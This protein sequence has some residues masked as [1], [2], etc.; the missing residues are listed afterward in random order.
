MYVVFVRTPQ[1]KPDALPNTVCASALAADNDVPADSMSTQPSA[2][3][4]NARLQ[5]VF[6]EQQSSVS[7]IQ[8]LVQQFQSVFPV[9]MPAGLP[10]DRGISHAIPMQTNQPVPASKMYRL[11]KPQRE[12]MDRQVKSLLKRGWIRPSSSPYGSPI[13]FTNKKDG[14]LRMCVDY[15]AVNKM[16]T[17]NSY[18]LPR[19][20]DLLD[21]LAGASI[22]SCLDLQQA[23]HQVR[24]LPE[25][26]PKTAFTTPQGLY[27]YLVLPFGLSNAPSTFQSVINA[28]LGPELA[29]CCLVYLDDIVV[30]SKTP[31]E[32]LTHLR[33]VLCKL[34]GAKLFAK[35]SKCKFALS[36]VKFCGH[37]IDQQGVLPDPD[38][39]KV[40]LDWPTPVDVHQLRSFVGLAQYRKFIQAFPIMIAPLT[41]LFKKDAEYKWCQAC[42]TAFNQVKTALTAPPCLKLPDPDEPFTMITDASGIGI[43]AVLMQAGRPVAF[44]GRKLTEPERKWSATEQEMLGVVYHMEK[45]RCYLDGV[46]FT[47]VTDHQPNTWFQSQKQ[48]SPRQARWYERLRGFGSTGLAGS[49]LLIL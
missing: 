43:G 14:G 25:D 21:K 31:E 18:P 41:A 1:D 28:I 32:H 20:D 48:L 15:R 34:Q 16:T 19:I 46:H 49:T 4:L 2:S 12:E 7:G 38:K 47:V 6:I 22:F 8:E 45:W 9:E 5:D 42:E 23:Y 26:I 36:S 37:V 39:I 27:E 10:P 30:F 40:V 17:R 13:L 44:E 35:L 11:S 29:H 24:L 3:E 33:L